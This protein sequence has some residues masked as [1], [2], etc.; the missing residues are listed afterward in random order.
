MTLLG[1]AESF[2]LC[3]SN[4]YNGDME[5]LRAVMNSPATTSHA[6]PFLMVWATTVRSGNRHREVTGREDSDAQY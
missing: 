4:R 3:Q 5:P 1:G 6:S 2:K